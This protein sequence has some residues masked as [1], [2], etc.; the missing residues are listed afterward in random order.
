MFKTSNKAL[1][2]IKSKT[3]GKHPRYL[4]NLKVSQHEYLNQEKSP[5]TSKPL[6]SFQECLERYFN[7]EMG[8]HLPWHKEGSPLPCANASDSQRYQNLTLRL[9]SMNKMDLTRELDCH[10]PC[11]LYEYEPVEFME[12]EQPCNSEWCQYVPVLLVAVDD[13]NLYLSREVVLY[14]ENNFI[15]DVGGYLGLLLGASVMTLYEWIVDA[16][17]LATS[18]YSK[19]RH[20]GKAKNRKGV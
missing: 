8:C 10:M 13:A 9:K 2:K 18:K 7:Q 12:V 4:Y 20:R 14:D 5:C 3:P 11:T 1:R 15:A 16:L 17:E 19:S 6:E